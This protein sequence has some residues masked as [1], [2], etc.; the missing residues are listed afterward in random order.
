MKEDEVKS[1]VPCLVM[2][3]IVGY[4]APLHLWNKGKISEWKDRKVYDVKEFRNKEEEPL[5]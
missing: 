3:R 1:K 4:Y 2:S 5:P